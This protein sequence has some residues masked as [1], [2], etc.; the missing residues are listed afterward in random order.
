MSAGRLGAKG[1]E[2]GGGGGDLASLPFVH[3]F[4][5]PGV[6]IVLVEVKDGEL[7]PAEGDRLAGVAPHKLELEP[8]VMD[9]RCSGHGSGGVRSILRQ[10][11]ETSVGSVHVDIAEGSI[12]SIEHVPISTFVTVLLISES[13]AQRLNDA[14]AGGQRQAVR[15]SEAEARAGQTR[16][17]RT[18]LG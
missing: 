10:C 1:F 6:G 17:P 15:A 14:H 11:A 13:P 8:N 4:L 9:R 12:D 7:H 2:G 5:I 3:K 18:Q 16:A